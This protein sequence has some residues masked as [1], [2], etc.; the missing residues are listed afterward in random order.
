MMATTERS[1]LAT[2]PSIVP[3][4]L[5]W[6]V[7]TVL[8]RISV[9]A[10]VQLGS[11]VRVG[12]GAVVSA[13]HQL[14]IGDNVSVGP[15]SIVQVDGEIGDWALIGMHVQIVGR[16]DHAIDEVGVPIRMATRVADRAAVPTDAVH[17]GKDVWIGASSVILSGVSIGAG[18]IIG[19]GSVVTK[20]IPEC[21]I[22]VGGPARVIGQRFNSEAERQS[23]LRI[24]D[25]ISLSS[26]SQ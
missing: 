8:R 1:A 20:D 11:N 5:R 9:G 18:S 3:A 15:H 13:P 24:L 16:N 26:T 14:N 6:V 23:H 22:A 2:E 17:I 21:S 10:N 19:A 7:R 12:R 4:P 25:G